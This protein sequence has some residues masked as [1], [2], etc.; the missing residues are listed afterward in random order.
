MDLTR[1]RRIVRAARCL[2]CIAAL[3]VSSGSAAPLPHKPSGG[4]RPL[5]FT[6]ATL[7]YL[8]AT[9]EVRRVAEWV[10]RTR[11]H[12]GAP[13]LII[14]KVRALAVLFDSTGRGRAAAPVLLGVAKGDTFPPGS[15]TKD[16]Y[17]TRTDE[18]ITPAGRFTAEPGVDNKGKSVLWL[19]YE[20]GIALHTVL[21]NPD[22]RRPQ[23]LASPSPDDN[24]IS[25]GCINVP[26]DFYETVLRPSFG[27][28]TGIVYVLPETLPTML[29][30]AE[31]A[32]Q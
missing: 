5:Q 12:H 3:A 32:R 9:S 10:L 30:L 25:Y 17:D 27:Q 8:P 6:P 18:R 14:D 31:Q 11:D 29:F 21:D 22:E 26:A 28:G 20:A 2:A 24:R 1:E 13:F 7:R 19:H 16:M 4:P 15:A 23:R